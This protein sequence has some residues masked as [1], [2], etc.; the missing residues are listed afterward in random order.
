MIKLLR[1]ILKLTK[2]NKDAVKAVRNDVLKTYI[3]CCSHKRSDCI[4]K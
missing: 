2:I 3:L 4:H 1:F